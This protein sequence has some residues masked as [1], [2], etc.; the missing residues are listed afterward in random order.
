M[1]QEK[2]IDLQEFELVDT[3]NVYWAST[4]EYEIEYNGKTHTIRIAEDD[5]GVEVLYLGEDGWEEIY[6]S[7]GDP[8]KDA[9]YDFYE[10]GGLS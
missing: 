8:M 2:L 4:D 1:E 3:K 5:N 6:G 7:S 10:E 9:L